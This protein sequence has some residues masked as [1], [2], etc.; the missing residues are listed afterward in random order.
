MPTDS[1]DN[2]Q[3]DK[4]G[5]DKI[6]VDGLDA[7]AAAI[8]TN[9]S[10]IFNKGYSPTELAELID[11]LIRRSQAKQPDADF[12]SEELQTYHK[13]S[14][15]ELVA[16][17]Y[18]LDSRFVQITLL[19]DQGAEAQGIRFTPDSQRKKYSSLTTLLAEIDDKAIVLLGKPGSGKTTLLRRLQLEHAW[20]ELENPTGCVAFFVPLNSYRRPNLSQP[21]PEPL[22]W[23]AAEWQIRQP[24]LPAFGT[25]YENGKLLLLLDGLNEMPHKDKADYRDRI[26]R[27]QTFWQRTW[28]YGNTLVFSC[29]S[30]DYSASLSGEV[31]VVRQTQVEPLSPRQIEEFLHLHLDDQIAENAWEVLR[32]DPQRLNLFSAPFF[33]RLLVDQIAATGTMPTGQAALLTS[34]VR[35]TLYREIAERRNRLFAP[36]SL[37]SEDD[38][39]QT[40][41]N[42]FADPYA[43]P[44]EGD[45]IP[46][47]E[48]LAYQMQAGRQTEEAGLV[49]AKTRQ[50]QKW[51]PPESAQAIINA[52]C[53]LN[54]LDKDIARREITY[55]HQLIQEYFAARVMAV[56]PQPELVRVLWQVDGVTPT[57]AET[58]AALE[59]SDPLP[60]LPATG[61]EETT[62][63]A[64]AM[65]QNQE[66]FVRDLLTPNLPLAARCAAAAEVTVSPRLTRQLQDALIARINNP[67]ADLRARMVAAETLGELGDPRFERR[68]GPHGDYLLPPLAMIAAGDYP[69]GDDGSSYDNEKPAHTVTLAEFEMAVFPVTNAEYR[70]FMRAGGYEDEQWWQTEAARAW[71]R[72]EGNSEGRKQSVRDDYQLIADWS[73]DRIRNLQTMPDQIDYLL[74]LQSLSPEELEKKMEEGFPSGQLYRQPEYWEDSR[75]NH[76]AQPVVGTTWFE[77]RAYC[78]WLS[79]QTGDLYALPTEAEWEAATRGQIGRIYAWGKEYSSSRCN[80]FETHIRATTPIGVFPDGRT[81]KTNIADLNGNVWEWTSTIWGSTRQ[82]SDFPYPYDAQD[83]RENPND[84]NSGRVVRGGSWLIIQNNMHGAFRFSFR[85]GNR[86]HVLGCR[87]RRSPSQ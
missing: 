42:A 21:L 51:L 69:L 79:A 83:G 36:G 10:V 34:F 39:Q 17:R 65:S 71:R 7:E 87:V 45:L 43:L 62:T 76:P 56:E 57:L 85:P 26:G 32:H 27:W 20:A 86:S 24:R 5:Q 60:R 49:R 77:A 12:T 4:V 50:A 48:Q 31:A 66:Q 37:F 30:L 23:L 53:Q 59:V 11:E 72:G 15:L 29:R 61:W 80:T 22:D 68:S 84:A 55:Y 14:V 28:Q 19:V 41:H 75:F 13:Q 38:Y 52:G 63:L 35:R 82:K 6:K 3:G 70:L 33:L 9:A 64:A 73:E 58:V 8:G 81:P 16:P 44:D 74:W 67:Q 47:L 2:V 40:L 46:S 1:S 78:A 54:I 25:L 18:Q